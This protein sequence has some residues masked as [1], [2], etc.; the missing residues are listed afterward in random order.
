M[1]RNS[2]TNEVS[3]YLDGV[4]QFNFSDTQGNA[5][6]VELSGNSIFRILHDDTVAGG[7]DWHNGSLDEI[8]IW[9]NPLS[10][11]EA[12]NAFATIPEPSTYCL[13]GSMVGVLISLQLNH[14]RRQ[15]HPTEQEN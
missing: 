14:R 12:Q 7:P 11:F 10:G 13:F 15:C 8:R 5:I 9:D 3:G 2:S 6:P 4:L 1:T